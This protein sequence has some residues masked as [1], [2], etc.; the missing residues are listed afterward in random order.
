M[1]SRGL[2]SWAATA[3]SSTRA[4]IASAPRPAQ[5]ATRSREPLLVERAAVAA[6]LDHAVGVEDERVAGR[7]RQRAVL[8]ARV[9]QHARAACRARRPAATLPSARSSSGSGWPPLAKPMRAPSAMR[10][11]VRVGDR[12]EAAVVAL[13]QQ[14]LVEQRRGCGSAAARASPPRAACSA[15]ARSRRRRR[16]PCRR[17]RPSPPS[18][19]ARRS[20]TGRRSRRPP[21]CPRRS[22]GSARRPRCRGCRAARRAAGSAGACARCRRARRTAGRCRPRWRSAGRAPRPARGR[23]S[24]KR[25]PDWS[26][27]SV[28][29]PSVRP[30]AII[31]TTSAE[32]IPKLAHVLGARAL[33]LGLRLELRDVG[34]ELGLARCAARSRRRAGRRWRRGHLPV[35]LLGPLQALGVAVGERD[36][37][38]ARLAGHV[39]GHPVGHLGHGQRR[40]PGRA[41]RSGSSEAASRALLSARKRCA[42]SARLWVVMSSITLIAIVT[43][44]S[45]SRIGVAL[46]ADQRSSPV[47]RRRKRTTSSAPPSPGERAAAGQALDRERLAAL[48]EDLEAI[49]DPVSAARTAAPRSTRS[50]AGRA[51]PRW[52]T[53]AARRAPGR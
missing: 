45:S 1:S 17:R 15:R 9:G 7:E 12:A 13:A 10:L 6:P 49:E 18:S 25:R 33:V 41:P 35:E 8:E 39:D 21:R 23:C 32:R 22:A 29:A 43:K 52:R 16:G 48:V 14:R 20:R 38:D 36:P 37:L 47:A 28:S 34:V 2:P 50:R 44:P 11:E 3:A 4:A 53:A 26:V 31:G 42:R 30:R 5:A 27:A 51:R 46:T 40:R 19:R 24:S